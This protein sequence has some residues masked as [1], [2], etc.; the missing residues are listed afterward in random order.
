[1][2]VTRQGDG[3]DYTPITPAKGCGCYYELQATGDA[4]ASCQSCTEGSQCP[5]SA[6]NCNLFGTPAVGFCEP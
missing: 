5:A 4:N 2:Q 1:M 3:T 6:P